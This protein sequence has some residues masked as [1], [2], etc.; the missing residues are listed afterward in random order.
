MN[1]EEIF[2]KYNLNYRQVSEFILGCGLSNIRENVILA[3]FWE[4]NSVGIYDAELISDKSTKI[5]LCSLKGKEF[6]YITTGMGAAICSDVVMSLKKTACKSIMFVGSAGALDEEMKIGDLVIPQ[7][8]VCGDGQCRYLKESLEQDCF[9]ES[10]RIEKEWFMQ[11]YDS[12]QA[13]AKKL[14]VSCHVGVSFSVESI[15]TQ[16]SHLDYIRSVG[17]NCIE[18]EAAAFLKASQL[19]GMKAGVVFCISDNAL[20]GQSLITVSEE[21]TSFRKNIRH[22]AIPSIIDVFVGGLNG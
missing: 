11:L 1:I 17:C 14:N 5:W 6:T 18:M 22:K 8:I 9:L 15:F 2:K 7:K 21:S 19:C 12:A 3:P 16:F 20:S 13:Q 4:P 10:Y